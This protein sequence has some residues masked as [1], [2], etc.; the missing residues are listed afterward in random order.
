MYRPTPFVLTEQLPSCTSE[1]RA[2]II[3]NRNSSSDVLTIRIAPVHLQSSPCFSNSPLELTSF[4]TEASRAV[5]NPWT[6]PAFLQR[7]AGLSEIPGLDQLSYRGQHGCLKSLDW[8]SFPTEASTAVWNP[9]TGPA[10]LQ[11]PAGLS[12]IPG[13]DQLSYRGQQ[14]C[15]KSLDWTSFPTEASRAP[16]TGR[17]LLKQG[18]DWD[19]TGD[20]LEMDRSISHSYDLQINIK[21]AFVHWC[22]YIT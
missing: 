6:G 3:T 5:W 10:F 11:R 20:G 1:Q 19:W 16:W 4:P 22:M 12:E 13:L 14:G 8:T 2:P 7:P 18:L 15:L 9:W 17:L 21:G